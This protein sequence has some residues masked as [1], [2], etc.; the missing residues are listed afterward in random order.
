MAEEFDKR[1]VTF[2]GGTEEERRKKEEDFWVKQA[3]RRKTFQEY[4][5]EPTEQQRGI[6]EWTRQGVL[7]IVHGYGGDTSLSPEYKIF[8]VVSGMVENEIDPDSAHAFISH[9]SRSIIVELRDSDIDVSMSLAHELF[10]ALSPQWFH[11]NHNRD[12]LSF[13]AGVTY[14]LARQEDSSLT[15]LDEAIVG[16]LSRDF[17]FTKIRSNALFCEEVRA[18]DTIKPWCQRFFRM[19]GINESDINLALDEI[20]AVDRKSTRLNSSHSAKSRMPSSA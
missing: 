3:E 20:Y 1:F 5:I 9:L 16:E 7:D 6:I 11:F 17:Y 4:A 2:T 10:H 19:A 15:I 12:G 13:R 8:F 14:S 18:V